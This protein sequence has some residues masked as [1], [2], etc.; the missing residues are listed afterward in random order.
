M[1]VF[2]PVYKGIHLHFP[3]RLVALR[4]AQ[5]MTVERLAEKAAMDL[6]KIQRLESGYAK[7]AFEDVRRIADALDVGVTA[8]LGLTNC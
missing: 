4:Q 1:C 7:P 5:R 3:A 6:L 2:T 8:L